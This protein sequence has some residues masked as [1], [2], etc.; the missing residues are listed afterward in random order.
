MR[1]RDTS[2][3]QDFKDFGK[4]LV[5]IDRLLCELPC[6]P[7]YQKLFTKKELDKL[8]SVWRHINKVHSDFEDIYL[9]QKHLKSWTKCSIITYHTEHKFLGHIP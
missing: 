6:K 8:V 5:I 1:R 9:K 3:E 7:Q 4:E 2:N